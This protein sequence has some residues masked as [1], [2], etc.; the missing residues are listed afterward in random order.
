M[1]KVQGRF[2]DAA[3]NPT[4]LQQRVEAAAAAKVAAEEQEQDAGSSDASV[5]CNVKWSRAEGGVRAGRRACSKAGGLRVCVSCLVGL[6]IP[7]NNCFCDGALP[8]RSA[9][10]S[11]AT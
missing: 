10:C 1:G 2:Y 9:T 7:S 4:P 11:A 6:P 8:I 5:P 3:G